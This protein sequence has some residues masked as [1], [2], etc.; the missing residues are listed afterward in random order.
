VRGV[1][2]KATYDPVLTI[3]PLPCSSRWGT[4]AFMPYQTLRALMAIR[5]S[6]A[7]SGVSMKGTMRPSNPAMWN[8][9]YTLPHLLIAVSTYP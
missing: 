1:P 5:S 2:W 3:D 8:A 6:K 4:S 9:P 7:S